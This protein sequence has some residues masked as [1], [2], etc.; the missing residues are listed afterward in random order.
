MN[1][2]DA[3]KG[4]FAKLVT[5]NA[6]V[7]DERLVNAFAAVPRERFVGSAPWSAFT[8]IGYI[9]IPSDDPAFL[10]QDVTVSLVKKESIN[11][12]QPTLHAR[13]LGALNIREG[14]TI[15]H[16]GAGTGYYTA[17]LSQLTGPKGSVIAYEID[18]SLAQRAA[19]N[20]AD[21][22]N[23]TIHHRSGTQGP[24]P[25]ADII[26]VN[27]GTTAPLEIW[28]DALSLGGRLLFPLTGAQG[29]GG[30]LLVTRTDADRY[31]AQFLIPVAFIPC[32]GA[33]DEETAQKLSAAFKRGDFRRVR[34]LFRHTSPDD[35]CWCSGTTWWLSTS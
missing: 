9:D 3:F 8:P 35:T 27:A 4:F 15:L 17:I 28:L 7:K 24:L 32:V 11:N 31:A 34:T 23:V 18:E 30:M 29:A 5:A 10:Y 19:G 6:G 26:Y 13:C 33:R 21:Y 2:L 25:D 22:P 14:D 12:G 16:I 1:R 20:L